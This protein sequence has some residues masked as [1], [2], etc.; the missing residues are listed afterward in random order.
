MVNLPAHTLHKFSARLSFEEAASVWTSYLSMYGLLINLAKVHENQFVVINAASSGAGLAAIQLTN[1][2]GGVSI[3]ITSNEAKKAALLKVGAAHVIVSSTQD[4]AAEIRSITGEKG[5][6][7]IIDPVG[8]PA[9]ASLV[10]AVAEFGQ[11]FV[12]GALS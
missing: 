12:Y 8:G 4:I 2:R 1:L 5:A 7:I 9:F 6:D 3:A 11:V 10:S